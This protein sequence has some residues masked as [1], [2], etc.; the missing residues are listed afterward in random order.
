DAGRGRPRP[1]ARGARDRDRAEGRPVRR[2][3]GAGRVS[4][5]LSR[6]YAGS[7]LAYDVVVERNVRVPT[8][9][10]LTLAADVYRP[11]LGSEPV[12]EAFP[13]ILERTPYSR[14]RLDLYLMAQRFAARGYA[15]VL[16]DCR[17]RYD[18]EGTFT[19]FL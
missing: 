1:A 8:R 19:F 17:G 16:Q 13:A 12:D 11:A 3:R 2:L 15:V 4:R 6:T 10:G 5:A 9:D 7:H 18:S 14:A